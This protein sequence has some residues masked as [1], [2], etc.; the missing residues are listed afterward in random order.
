[1]D[2]RVARPCATPARSGSTTAPRFAYLADKTFL[3]A[4]ALYAVNRFWGK[5]LLGDSLHFLRSHLDDCLLIPAALPPLLYVF[6]KLGLRRDDSPPSLR[7]V[8]EWTLL[9]SIAFEWA[10]PRFLHKGVADWRDV[11][12][13]AAGALVSWLL[14][15]RGHG[16]VNPPPPQASASSASIRPVR[17]FSI[18]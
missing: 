17:P 18:R 3:T 4:C 16:P 5:P 6:R 13:Y 14:W 2:L 11:L 10:F 15:R 9:W 8:G 1:M 12:A 7:E